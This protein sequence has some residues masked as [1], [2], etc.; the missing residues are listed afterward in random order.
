MTNIKGNKPF[1]ILKLNLSKDFDSISLFAIVETLSHIRFLYILMKWIQAYISSSTF[2]YLGNAY[3][4]RWFRNN[5]DI[6]QGGPLLPYFFIVM[7]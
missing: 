4:F 6:R 3:A 1:T 5:S 7:Q 2:A